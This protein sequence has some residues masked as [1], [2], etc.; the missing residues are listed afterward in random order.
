MLLR[1]ELIPKS[2]IYPNP[3][4]DVQRLYLM[5]Q[6]TRRNLPENMIK[7]PQDT[8]NLIAIAHGDWEIKNWNS[9]F[10]LVIVIR[11]YGTGGPATTWYCDEI[12]V[13]GKNYFT[14]EVLKRM[15]RS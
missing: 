5:S 10:P 15:R 8:V 11:D 2:N 9:P 13:E 6:G 14:E 1:A 4:G 3:K 7:V 12:Y